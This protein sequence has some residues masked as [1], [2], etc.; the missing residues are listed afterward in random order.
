MAARFRR[1]LAAAVVILGSATNAAA[2]PA[3]VRGVVQD[4]TGNPVPGVVVTVEHP[5][6]TAVRVALTDLQ[7]AYEVRELQRGTR[8]RIEIS[9]P[10][11]RKATLRAEPGE[12]V[13]VK[14]KPRRLTAR[15]DR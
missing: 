7:G 8:Y 14:L 4:S 6:Q 9:H 13:D 1:I 2:Q 5:Q 3:P 12:R 10:E 11:F 15:R